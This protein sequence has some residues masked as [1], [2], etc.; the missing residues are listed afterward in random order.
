VT[1]EGYFAGIQ[2]PMAMVICKKDMKLVSAST[3]KLH[4]YE[5]MYCGPLVDKAAPITVNDFKHAEVQTEVNVH[6]GEQPVSKTLPKAAQSI[7]SMR[8]HNIPTPL[9]TTPSVLRSPTSLDDSAM[10]QSPDPGEGLVL[11]EHKAYS[12]VDQ[13]NLEIR[14]LKN[15]VESSVGEPSIRE[16]LMA[17]LGKAANVSSGEIGHGELK[18]EKA[19]AKY[20][21]SSDDV[22]SGKRRKV[23][24]NSN[25]VKSKTG[26]TKNELSMTK[27]KST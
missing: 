24:S 3:K 6:K 7:K 12:S 26:E 17:A 21:V 15:K 14:A 10:S 20:G 13:L 27:P 22:I 2:H 16:K 1:V 4:V 8:A 23:Y 25:V 5:Y 9:S 19:S 11:P 18:N